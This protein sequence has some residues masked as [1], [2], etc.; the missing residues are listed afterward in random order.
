MSTLKQLDL[1]LREFRDEHHWRWELEDERGSI[2]VHVVDLDPNDW[3]YKGFADLQGYLKANRA[4]HRERLAEIARWIGECVFGQVA[5]EILKRTPAVVRVHVPPEAEA[6]LSRPLEL[7]DL[8][9]GLHAAQ[10]ATFIYET[11]GEAGQGEDNHESVVRMLAVFSLPSDTYGPAL[12]TRRERSALEELVESIVTRSKEIEL[13]ILQYGVTREELDRALQDGDGW[14][15]VHLSGHGVPGALVLEH[16]DGSHDLLPTEKLRDLLWPCRHRLRL[17]SLFSCDS[18]AT[19]LD[20]LRRLELSSGPEPEAGASFQLLQPSIARELV[21]LGCAVVA[22]RRPVIDSFA[23][24]LSQELYRNL[25]ESR[26]SLPA[27]LQIALRRIAEQDVSPLSLTAP[28]LY[29]ASAAVLSLRPRERKG[30][31][32]VRLPRVERSLVSV[33]PEADCFVGRAGSLTRMSTAILGSK[34]DLGALLYGPAGVGATACATELTY[35]LRERFS[36][37]VW[38]CVPRD[39]ERVREGAALDEFAALFD[40]KASTGEDP[41]SEVVRDRQRLDAELPAL[42][43]L[44]EKLP[45]LVVLDDVDALFAPD[46]AWWDPRW[47]GLIDALTGHNGR[48]RVIMTSRRP[49]PAIAKRLW[50]ERLGPLTLSEAA[51]MFGE[52]D[53]LA[54][55]LRSGPVGRKLTQTAFRYAQG[56]PGLLR[57]AD[58]YASEPELLAQLL[59]DIQRAGVPTAQLDQFLLRERCMLTDQQLLELLD[60]WKRG[61]YLS[62]ST[63]ERVLLRLLCVL[64]EPDRTVEALTGHWRPVWERLY[65]DTELPALEPALKVLA[66]SS[67]VIP[68]PSGEGQ[69]ARY[70]I[71]AKVSAAG[72]A[73]AGEDFVRALSDVTHEASE[74]NDVR[75]EQPPP[76]RPSP[77][78]VSTQPKVVTFAETNEPLPSNSPFWIGRAAVDELLS[79]MQT[80]GEFVHIIAPR[81]VGKSSVLYAALR[82]LDANE[83]AVVVVDFLASVHLI[84]DLDALC[85]GVVEEILESLEL[86]SEYPWDRYGQATINFRRVI[87]QV[88]L[89]A[90]NRPFFLVLDHIEHL[91]DVPHYSTF[92]SGLRACHTRRLTKP[93]W[94]RFGL[95]LVGQPMPLVL[96]PYKSPF[97]IGQQIPLQDF[98]DEEVRTLVVRHG[99]PVADDDVQELAALT[100]G[101]PRLTQTV[102]NE[103]KRGHDATLD[104]LSVKLVAVG[105]PI[106]DMLS[107]GLNQLR[108]SPE[109]ERALRSV[110][111]GTADPDDEAVFRLASLGWVRIAGRTV[112]PRGRLFR[113]YF[114]QKLSH[115]TSG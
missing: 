27:S 51:L 72:R 29:G 46:K 14:D 102:L 89:P 6:L 16:A 101:S 3:Q 35:R 56:H 12:A 57:I 85:R 31:G 48:S 98:S 32:K 60:V 53:T 9:D 66:T 25:F 80:P 113:D 47:Q 45:I 26:A 106:G 5:Q 39:T 108:S 36:T 65:P 84:P 76:T 58:R 8:G 100:G 112:K 59:L 94:D 114:E 105:T 71:H 68:E 63:H 75:P 103:L 7:A 88:V 4:G 10:K 70:R 22:M 64:D 92:F 41:L 83:A 107:E 104:E 42:R 38:Y 52:L 11:E 73:A 93:E 77:P 24:D 20:S 28:A 50:T 49:L 96:S 30:S 99:R 18:A 1:H 111:Q 15:V 97:N 82:A 2:R 44:F 33:P 19:A 90:S 55:L 81:D 43:L 67:L 69:T 110:L 78:V 95:V 21:S 62:L 87:E 54:S 13:R 86:G 17:I 23:I 40:T 91:V 79:C 37:V 61:A 115:G 74:P 34:Q 109:L